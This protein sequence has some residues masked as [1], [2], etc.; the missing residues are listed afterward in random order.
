[1]VYTNSQIGGK[2]FY[3]SEPLIAR[4][5]GII[6]DYPEGVGILKELIQNADDAKATRVEIIL[7]WRTHKFK[8]LPDNRIR[9]VVAHAY[10]NLITDLVEDIGKYQPQKFYEFFPTIKITTSKALEELHIFVIRLLYERNVIQSAVEHSEIKLENGEQVIHSTKWVAPTKIK[11][12]PK[13]WHRKLVVPLSADEIDIS[14][15]RI[16]DKILSAFVEASYKIAEFKPVDLRNHL[17]MNQSL[18]LPLKNAPKASLKNRQWV[19]DMLGYCVEDNYQDLQGLPLAI[20]ANN[21][22]EVFGYS[23]RN[24]I[25]IHTSEIQREIFADYP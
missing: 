22:L 24:P 2:S 1:M 23:S 25:F 18:G 6:R 15:P 19:I 10:A 7:D 12:L 11:V 16:P 4:L 14:E 8:N 5:R 9:H 17:K 20:L 21:Y 3:Q 13:S